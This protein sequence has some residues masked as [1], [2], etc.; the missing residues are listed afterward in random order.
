M[1]PE[2]EDKNY[3]SNSYISGIINKVKGKGGVWNPKLYPGWDKPLPEENFE[4]K[5]ETE[6]TTETTP[7]TDD[8]TSTSSDDTTES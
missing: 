5:S 3:N 2:A 8:T 7:T 6:T 1:K 4:K